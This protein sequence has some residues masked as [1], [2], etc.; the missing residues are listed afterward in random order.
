MTS[1]ERA[2]QLRVGIFMAIGLLAIGLMVV[3]FGR[4][5]ESIHGAYKIRVE[6]PNASGIYR[7]ASVLLAG[8]KIGSVEN[9]PV[10]LPNMDGVYVDLRIFEEVQIPTAAEFTIGSSGLLGDRF[11]QIVLGKDAKSAPPIAPGAVI[12]GKSEAGMGDVFNQAASLLTDVQTAV[13]NIN[14]VAEKLNTEV[15]KDTTMANLSTTLANLKE[16]STAVSEASKKIDGVVKKAGEA[17]DSGKQTFTSANETFTSANQT[18]TSAKSAADDLKKAVGDLRS[19]IQQ[20][21]QGRGVLAALISD[22][23]MAENLRALVSN[24]RRSGILWYKDRPPP[25]ARSR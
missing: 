1:K 7:G 12:Q 14:K 11:I 9:N 17:I 25:E 22:R 2:S 18:F 15:F 6:Y 21:K 23:E 10:I 19:L 20:A 3:Y 5:G 13:G 16:A 8:A 4:F 24:L